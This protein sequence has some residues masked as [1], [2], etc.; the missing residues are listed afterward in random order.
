MPRVSTRYVGL[1]CGVD[2]MTR[3]KG[4]SL[5]KIIVKCAICGHQDHVPMFY[6]W[7]SNKSG[8]APQIYICDLHHFHNRK[9]TNKTQHVDDM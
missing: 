1:L 6:S 8:V 4:H 5:P 3:E 9:Q 7:Y 2:T